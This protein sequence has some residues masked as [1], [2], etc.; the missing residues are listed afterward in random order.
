V[1]SQRAGSP[2]APPLLPNGCPDWSRAQPLFTTPEEVAAA[3]DR[4]FG[5]TRPS[6]RCSRRSRWS[7]SSAISPRSARRGSRRRRWTGT[8]R[9]SPLSSARRSGDGSSGRIPSRTS[10]G[11]ARSGGRRWRIRTVNVQA[12]DIETA[13]LLFVVMMAPASAAAKAL[14]LRWRSVLLADPDRPVLRVEETWT[15]AAS[16]RRSQ[17]RVSGRLR[18]GSGWTLLSDASSHSRCQVEASVSA[19]ATGEDGI[20]VNAQMPKVGVEPTRPFGHRILSPARLP[21]PPLRR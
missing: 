20:P 9:R 4:R 3:R 7:G 5:L 1:S 17:S 2:K 14:G 12:A 16:I 19:Q 8:L 10:S 18:S 6:V 21:V 15:P 13:R 11:H